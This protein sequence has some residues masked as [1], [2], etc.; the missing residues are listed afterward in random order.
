MK[1]KRPAAVHTIDG[2]KRLLRHR[3]VR[4]IVDADGL[5]NVTLECGHN[6]VQI[7]PVFCTKLSCA[8]CIGE[9]IQEHKQDAK[10]EKR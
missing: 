4:T 8:Q 3:I 9:L 7:I 10:R 1:K 6:S 5:Q 2:D